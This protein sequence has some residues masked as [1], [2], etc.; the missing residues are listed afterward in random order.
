MSEAPCSVDGCDKPS[1]KGGLCCGH[2]KRKQRGKRVAGE[3]RR[4]RQKPRELVLEAVLHLAEVDST[5][6]G[7]WQ[8]AWARLRAAYTRAMRPR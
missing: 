3:I 4:Y 2:R 7:A 8:R 1:E 5:D 6:K